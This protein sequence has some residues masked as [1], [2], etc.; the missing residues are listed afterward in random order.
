[1]NIVWFKRDLSALYPFARDALWKLKSDHGV[2]RE[3]VRFLDQHV[4]QRDAR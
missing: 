4:E 1:M 2:L 3:K